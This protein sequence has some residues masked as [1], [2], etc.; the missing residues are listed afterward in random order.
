[1]YRDFEYIGI[2]ISDP[3]YRKTYSILATFFFGSL[4]IGAYFSIVWLARRYIFIRFQIGTFLGCIV[5]LHILFSYLVYEHFIYFTHLL[6]IHNLPTVYQRHLDQFAAINWWKIPFYFYLTGVFTYSLFYNYLFYAVGLKLIKDLFVIKMREDHL[7]KEN[8]QL[9][10][11]FLKAQ[12]NPHF[13]FNTL[14]NI[15]AFSIKSPEQVSDLILKLAE[16]MRYSL[17]ETEQAFVPLTKELTFLESYVYLQRI[18]H[19]KTIQF[20]YEILG[21]PGSSQVPPFILIVFVENAF[22]HGVQ[23]STKAGWLSIQLLIEKN[24]LTFTVK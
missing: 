22:K 13:L 20:S 19:E 17:Y 1:M 23:L 12:V 18:R 16:L 24:I 5:L 2:V 7:Q 14:N 15:Y 4:T 8:I 11:N 9:E 6:T 3:I 21:E 10:F